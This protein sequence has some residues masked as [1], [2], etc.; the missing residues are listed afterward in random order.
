MQACGRDLS[1]TPP[2]IER[3]MGP[4]DVGKLRHEKLRVGEKWFGVDRGYPLSAYQLIG[5][6]Y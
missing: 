2:G 6:A 1:A 5:Y 3:V 4:F